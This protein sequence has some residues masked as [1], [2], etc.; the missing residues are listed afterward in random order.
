MRL[1]KVWMPVGKRVAVV[2][3]TIH[4]CELAEFLIKRGRTVTIVH[5]G[6]TLGEGMTSDDIFRFETWLNSKNAGTLTGVRYREINNNGLVIEDKD[7]NLQTI[8][9]DTV[10]IARPLQPNTSLAD[11]LKDIAPEFYVIG[12]CKEAG[13]ITEAVADGAIISNRI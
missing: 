6:E 2:G 10:I 11:N 9:A 12:D 1:S 8:E 4:G 3:G 13:L 5:D 7:G